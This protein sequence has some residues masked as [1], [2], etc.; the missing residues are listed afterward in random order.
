MGAAATLKKFATAR[1]KAYRIS[2]FFDAT[3]AK[4]VSKVRKVADFFSQKSE[5]VQLRAVLQCESEIIQLLPHPDSRFSKMRTD[6]LDLIE[7]A[8]QFKRATAHSGHVSELR[9]SSIG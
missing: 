8:K 6:M 4:A 3:K 2:G 7:K 5:S 1:E 9:Q